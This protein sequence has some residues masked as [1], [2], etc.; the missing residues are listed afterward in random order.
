MT[1]YTYK[2]IRALARAVT[3]LEYLNL[4]HE[5]SSNAIASAIGLPK[6]TSYRMLRSLIECG[7]VY[8]SPS[9]N[10]FRLTPRVEQLGTH[11]LGE[12]CVEQV[13]KPA[14][15]KLSLRML[16]PTAYSV[17]D[18]S[19][20]VIKTRTHRTSPFALP[21]DLQMRRG[22]RTS[23]AGLVMLAFSDAD[24]RSRFLETGGQPL[25]ADFA[26]KLEQIRADGFAL[27]RETDNGDLA[28][29]AVPV[30][31]GDDAVGSLHVTWRPSARDTDAIML[32]RALPL[33][34]QASRDIE[35]ALGHL[36]LTDRGRCTAS[37]T[38]G[39]VGRKSCLP[40]EGETPLSYETK[41]GHVDGPTAGVDLTT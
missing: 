11:C 38:R 29:L 17:P 12:P 30:L 40:R 41:V 19:A 10:G 14:L 21:E 9:Q 7:L 36:A 27:K 37:G 31:D 34:L 20:M 6:T 22:M 23:A 18:G 13:I 16:W 33:F 3:V 4:A 25:P 28:A 24:Q 32:E 39:G 2:R 15:F 8:Y 5:S 1:A 35:A 26:Q